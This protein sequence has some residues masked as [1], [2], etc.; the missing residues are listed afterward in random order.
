MWSAIWG[1]IA[2]I[3]QFEFKMLEAASPFFNKLLIVVGFIA[4]VL[5]LREMSRDKHVENFD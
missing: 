3:F 5:W 4:F 1:F 2:K